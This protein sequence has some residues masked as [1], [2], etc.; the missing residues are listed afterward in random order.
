MVGHPLNA[1]KVSS[2]RESTTMRTE[3]CY[4]SHCRFG[5][6][7][8]NVEFRKQFTILWKLYQYQSN[9]A[10]DNSRIIKSYNGA[11]PSCFAK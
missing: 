9:K 1:L 8:S 3:F 5:D 4:Q 11:Q 10:L 2:G 6:R 7:F